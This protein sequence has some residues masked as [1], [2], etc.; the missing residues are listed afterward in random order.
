MTVS[1]YFD[2][3]CRAC[4]WSRINMETC[5]TVVVL[6]MYNICRYV[7]YNRSTRVSESEFV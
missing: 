6:A 3:S 7:L 4:S 1:G 2:C 5:A